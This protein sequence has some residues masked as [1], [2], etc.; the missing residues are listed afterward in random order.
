MLSEKGPTVG[1]LRSPGI[2]PLLRYYQPLR[3][4]LLFD[5]FP[6]RSG[7]TAYLAPPLSQREEEG[8][9]SC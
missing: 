3:H 8:F 5:R 6:G 7:Y 2:T 4:P 9:S 1:L